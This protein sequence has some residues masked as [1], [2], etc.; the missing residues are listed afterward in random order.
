VSVQLDSSVEN[1]AS[2]QLAAGANLVPGLAMAVVSTTS[3]IRYTG[4]YQGRHRETDTEYPGCALLLV[5]LT[6]S[7]MLG[8]GAGIAALDTFLL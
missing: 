6:L 2:P 5:F 3:R 7:G 4:R 8:V 1:L